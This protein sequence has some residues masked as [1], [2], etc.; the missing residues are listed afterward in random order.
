MGSFSVARTSSLCTSNSSP[1]LAS[2]D[3][4]TALRIFDIGN[5]V[6]K[7]QLE[8]ALMKNETIC[9]NRQKQL[10]WQFEIEVLL[11]PKNYAWLYRDAT[12]F[13]GKSVH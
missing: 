5:K 13:L 1:T 11:H 2:D 4:I 7:L 8:R 10:P 6:P 9:S 12:F 3:K